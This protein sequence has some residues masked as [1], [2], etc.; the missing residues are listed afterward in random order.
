MGTGGQGGTYLLRIAVSR[1]LTVVFGRFRRGEP[2]PV[3]RGALVYVGSAL[4]EK[5][6]ASLARRL[7]R[8]ATRSGGKPPH[9]LR[10]EMTTV[11]S[12]AGL[13]GGNLIPKNGK[14]LRWH[15]DFLLD[16][17]AAEIDRVLI[18]R[19]PKR[20][21]STVAHILATDPRAAPLAA[22]LGAADAPGETHLFRV[23]GDDAWWE[24]LAERVRKL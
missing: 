1:P 22:G 5:G 23:P 18:I 4:A 2:V 19:S 21:E 3:P 9:H 11:F 20:L 8:H 15:I 12:A 6:A 16:E 14:K 17:S 24:I 10:A 13:G 7:L